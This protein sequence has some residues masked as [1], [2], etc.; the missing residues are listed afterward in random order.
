MKNKYIYISSDYA[1]QFKK[2]VKPFKNLINI[3]KLS[4]NDSCVI[5]NSDGVINN[6][7]LYSTYFDEYFCNKQINIEIDNN[8]LKKLFKNVKNG[9]VIYIEVRED[10]PFY[11]YLIVKNKLSN[12]NVATNL[13]INDALLLL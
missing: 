2:I 5:V 10:D 8:T 4:F 12:K 7:E 11:I 6:I 3:L 13:L 1:Y 9:D